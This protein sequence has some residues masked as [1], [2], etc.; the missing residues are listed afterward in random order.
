MEYRTGVPSLLSSLSVSI[1]PCRSG[2][3]RAVFDVRGLVLFPFSLIFVDVPLSVGPLVVSC[4]AFLPFVFP[5]YP[6]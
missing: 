5:F 3:S 4:F 6:F 1:N 2:V